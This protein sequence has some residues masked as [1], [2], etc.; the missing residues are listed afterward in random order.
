MLKSTLRVFMSQW[1]SSFV[2]FYAFLLLCIGMQSPLQAQITDN[3]SDGELTSNPGWTGDIS[4]FV[5]NAAGEM[6]W[7]EPAAG[8]SPLAVQGNISSINTWEFYSRM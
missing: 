3:F 5:L 7:M 6:Q 8:N 2:P 4:N 1:P